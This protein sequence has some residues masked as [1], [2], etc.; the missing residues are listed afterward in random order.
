[1]SKLEPKEISSHSEDLSQFLKN[2]KEVAELTCH[3]RPHEGFRRKFRELFCLF[4]WDQTVE[5]IAEKVVSLFFFKSSYLNNRGAHFILL[6]ILFQ[7]FD[8]NIV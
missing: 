5:S 2:R 1:M 8:C 7:V 6:D 4:L 3:E